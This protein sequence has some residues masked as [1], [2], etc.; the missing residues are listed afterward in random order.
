MKLIVF[1]V[2]F[3]VI[4]SYIANA[5]VL[6]QDDFDG[7]IDGLENHGWTVGNSIS[8]VS[9]TECYSGRCAK[10]QFTSEGTSDY[11][12]T[13]HIGYNEAYYQ[14]RF[15]RTNHTTCGGCKF[16]KLRAVDTWDNYANITFQMDYGSGIIDQVD[17]GCGISL[18]NDQ[19]CGGRLGNSVTWNENGVVVTAGQMYDFPDENWH[20]FEAY[21]K[22]NS[23]GN[24]DGAY[25]MWVD[26]VKYREVI[27]VKMRDDQN[28]SAFS[29]M[30][31]GDYNRY[32]NC[33]S[34]LYELYYDNVVISDRYIGTGSSL[35]LLLTPILVLPP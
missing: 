29:Y 21:V 12:L 25:T 18:T 10:I 19:G 6:F 28:P 2:F 33:E 27:N 22:L 11:I 35:M 8:V 34:Y 24:A 4:S 17:H 5:A 26:G 7:Y 14:F 30:L 31:L 9:G 16:L 1:S 20:V 3:A 32:D 13:R 15:K 23:D